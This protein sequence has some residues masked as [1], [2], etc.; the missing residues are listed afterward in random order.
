M[1]GLLAAKFPALT[2][3]LDGGALLN[4]AAQRT[5][6]REFIDM[7][8][9]VETQF[10]VLKT[11]VTVLLHD[12]LTPAEIQELV[13]DRASPLWTA[14][15]VEVALKQRLGDRGYKVFIEGFASLLG[16][17]R[18]HLPF[19]P[20][21]QMGMVA[22][23][24]E[25][26]AGGLDASQPRS[27]DNSQAYHSRQSIE[28]IQNINDVLENIHSVRRVAEN[29][30]AVATGQVTIPTDSNGDEYSLYSVKT[31]AGGE[32]EDMTLSYLTVSLESANGASSHLEEEALLDT[33]ATACAISPVFAQDLELE[34]EPS[35][36]EQ[37]RTVALHQILRIA[38]K[39]QL[40]M[41]W[42][43]S[44]GGKCGTKIWVKLVLRAELDVMWLS[45]LDK[46]S[47]KAQQE[48]RAKRLEENKASATASTSIHGQ[49]PGS[50]ATSTAGS[51]STSNFASTAPSVPSS[52]GSSKASPPIS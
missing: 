34:M 51:S 40:K 2:S 1:T 22:Q 9:S 23:A 39:A 31:E 25:S 32:G 30:E 44:Q 47:Q 45:K 38:G 5:F 11:T 10:I 21:L 41:R 28:A 43:D 3:V 8:R 48:L 52:A 6:Q 50:S 17:N 12:A 19:S 20:S 35:E 27:G 26:S 46:K 37:I 15:K 42:K 18:Q 7:A 13:S 24:D 29:V 16:S 36:K 14:P 4:I 49:G 33:G